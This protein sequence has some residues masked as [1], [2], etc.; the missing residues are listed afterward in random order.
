MNDVI[1]EINGCILKV[2]LNRPQLRNAFNSEVI[3]K[4]THVF[5]SLSCNPNLRL[6]LISGNGPDFCAGADLEWMRASIKLSKKENYQDA[7][8]LFAMYEAMENCHIP[9]I[10]QVHGHIFGGGIGLCAASDIVIADQRSIFC[11]SEAK[12]GLIP[13]VMMP[14]MINKLGKSITQLLLIAGRKFSTKDAIRYGL[15]H[16]ASRKQNLTSLT[17]DI[18]KNIITSAPEAIDECRRLIRSSASLNRHHFVEA[19]ANKRVGKEAQE[20]ISAFFENR[21]P[22]WAKLTIDDE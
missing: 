15:A 20:G 4:L 13:A 10:T 8:K 21:L 17:H 14:L 1:I 3:Q 22:S 18:I 12:L 9:I 2:I 16:F 19:L 5:L 11:L 7:D 6:I